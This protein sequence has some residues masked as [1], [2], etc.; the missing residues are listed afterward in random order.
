MTEHGDF[1]YDPATRI[2]RG[3][4]LPFGERS[5]T[6]ISGA[7]PI[8]FGDASI[9]LPRDPSVVTLNRYHNRHDPVGRAT[10]LEKWPQG[11]YSEF[12]IADTDEG[13][14]YIRDNLDAFGKPKPGSLRKLS[15]EVTDMVRDG[16]RAV[17]AR[18][19][20]AALVTDGAFASAA[21][22]AAEEAVA[23]E[24]ASNLAEVV[25]G[26]RGE[27]DNLT[28]ILD[29]LT[30]R[31]TEDPEDP[32]KKEEALMGNIVPGD[33]I[34]TTPR[35]TLDGLF[36]AIT[37]NDPDS[38]APYA[39]AGDLF[40]LS[41]VQHSGPTSL[42][43]GAD[44]QETGYLGELWTRAPYQRRF[45]PLVGQATLT[46]YTMRGWR[47]VDGKRPEVG[48]YAGNTAEVPSNPVD[49]EPVDVTAARLA[50]GHRLDRRFRDFN[51]QAVIG[52]YLVNQT[53]DYKRKTDGKVL[54]AIGSAATTTAPGTVPAGIAK[55]L[56]AVVDGALGV[57]ATENRPSYA[58][59]DPALWRDIVLTPKDDVLAFLNAG[60]GLEEG[61]MAGFKLMPA[62]VGA[63]K[64]LVGAKEALT[65]YELGDT[66]IRVDG[67]QP[68]NGAEDVAVF[69]YWATLTN[70]GAAIRSVTVAA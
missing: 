9:T 12:R 11:V 21:L 57:I 70:N 25:A 65:Y 23:E 41:T 15:A 18:L 60:F 34:T 68:G 52:S 35:P 61:D 64:V 1:S 19:T 46:N 48:D 6:S 59:I 24:V 5:R 14:A 39:G 58:L 16:V 3:I 38:L 31:D 7:E 37:R 47:W 40:A 13:D 33:G 63:G 55:G 22:F 43:I 44:T 56:A 29:D 50:G 10:L 4:L 2:L 42:T 51:D 62:A 53:E 26:F 54:A 28:T 67:V 27:L 30:K 66:P 49:T 45:V 32:D 20:G 69:G 17:R 8:E 36:A